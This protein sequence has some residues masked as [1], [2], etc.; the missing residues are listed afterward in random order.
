MA[1]FRSSLEN[2]LKSSLKDEEQLKHAIF[3]HMAT[4]IDDDIDDVRK[5]V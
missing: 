2:N 3:P 1:S 4:R 5:Q